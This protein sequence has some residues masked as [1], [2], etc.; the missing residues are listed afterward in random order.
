[1]TRNKLTMLLLLFAAPYVIYRS[2]NILWENNKVLSLVT[3]LGSR[4]QTNRLILGGGTHERQD[5]KIVNR[6]A[7][8][9]LSKIY[10]KR[11]NKRHL[12]FIFFE[13]INIHLLP[14]WW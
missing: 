1:M 7:I 9:V 13:N 8:S 2:V 6:L 12:F 11:N 4:D 14:S 10:N 5:Y 3:R